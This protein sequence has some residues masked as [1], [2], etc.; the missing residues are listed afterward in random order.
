MRSRVSLSDLI[1]TLTG[2]NPTIWRPQR[3][4]SEL[5][6]ERA[7]GGTAMSTSSHGTAAQ[8][9]VPAPTSMVCGHMAAA[10]PMTQGLL[11]SALMIMVDSAGQAPLVVGAWLGLTHRAN[12]LG[13]AGVAGTQALAAVAVPH[14]VP[15]LAIAAD[16]G[17]YFAIDLRAHRGGRKRVRRAFRRGYHRSD[18]P[19]TLW[20]LRNG[21]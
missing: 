16:A 7:R 15:Y 1:R 4:Q 14:D 12:L 20:V 9:R 18:A 5:D 13:I 8:A 6:L 17:N 19:P 11:R 3:S 21:G 2:A 10:V